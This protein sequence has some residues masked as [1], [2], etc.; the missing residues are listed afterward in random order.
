VVAPSLKRDLAKV[1]AAGSRPV[2]RS[3]AIRALFLAQ[4]GI[5]GARFDVRGIV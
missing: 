3:V 1:E 2:H 4:Y 5:T